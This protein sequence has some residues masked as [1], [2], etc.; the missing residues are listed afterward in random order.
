MPSSSSNVR[1]ASSTT[2]SRK[3]YVTA[4]EN[5]SNSNSN[6]FYSAKSTSNFNNNAGPMRSSNSSSKSSSSSTRRSLR[7]RIPSLPPMPRSFSRIS[8]FRE[9]LVDRVPPVLRRS[10]SMSSLA[11]SAR[12]FLQRLSPMRKSSSIVAPSTPVATAV[13][14]RTRP[15]PDLLP[16]LTPKKVHA[17]IKRPKRL[18][19]IG[20]PPLDVMQRKIIKQRFTSAL[21][22]TSKNIVYFQSILTRLAHTRYSRANF[23]EISIYLKDLKYYK[24]IVSS[25]YFTWRTSKAFLAPKGSTFVTELPVW[26][27]NPYTNSVLN[28]AVVHKSHWVGGATDPIMT[29]V[30]PNIQRT[31]NRQIG[32]TRDITRRIGF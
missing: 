1:R 22:A 15:G 27:L 30:S 4:A 23:D 25:Q 7:S 8:S 9:A 3:T 6:S 31:V 20:V 5:L 28:D 11:S 18:P 2:S 24:K 14:Q 12:G 26:P 16:M 19:T 10:K 29:A 21:E 17:L 32:R 13:P